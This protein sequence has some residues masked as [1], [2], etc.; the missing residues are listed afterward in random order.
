MALKR[1]L[2]PKVRL[3]STDAGKGP[4]KRVRLSAAHNEWNH[5]AVAL[6]AMEK[7][8]F[9]EEGLTDVELISFDE[10]TDQLID[11]EELQVD[12]VAQGVV[13]VAI[14]P[15]ATFVLEAKEQKRPV[16]VVAA[17]RLTHAFILIGQKG[18]KDIHE[19]RG[20]S[21]DMGQRGGATDVMMRQV[22][23]DHGL[24]P[25]RDVKFTYSGGPMH[26]L[27]HHAKAFREGKRGPASLTTAR[28]LEKFLAEG[29]PVLADLRKLYP[30]RHDRIT[31][32]NEDFC[33]EHPEM[34][35]A[36]LKGLIRGCRFVL[37]MDKE[38]FTQFI[39]E[40]GF[41]ATEREVDSYEPLFT[42]WEGRISP[43]LS[44][45]MEG[46]ELIVD[47]Q[48]RAGRL[49]PSF[50]ANDVLRLEEL[51]KAQLELGA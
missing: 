2:Q 45:P 46:I 35:K 48:K 34:L 4:R 12:L 13:D 3:S 19:L 32:A 11:R 21:L 8:F 20:S 6:V 50:K 17:R 38:W 37:K 15:R 26:D 42:A 28:E 9:E 25:D 51:K 49:A 24:E 18:L 14:D 47:E 10:E 1:I 31:A 7:G 39:K 5:L 23:K 29:Y 22:L 44:L 33:R 41:L 36:V 43:D 30:P 16:C 40:C 27:A